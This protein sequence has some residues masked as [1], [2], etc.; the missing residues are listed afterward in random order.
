MP[1]LSERCAELATEIAAQTAD[2]LEDYSSPS[3]ND[4][5]QQLQAGAYSS[6]EYQL[7]TI[8]TASPWIALS[9]LT[10][11]VFVSFTINAIWLRFYP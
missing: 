2:S 1:T 7:K 9:A 6:D 4:L 10:F 11:I 5:I 8:G 3:S